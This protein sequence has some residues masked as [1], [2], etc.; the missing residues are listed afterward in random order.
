VS[1]ARLVDEEVAARLASDMT[2]LVAELYP[3]CRSI[4][5]DG[6]RTTLRRIERR[7]PLAVSEVPSGTPVY[8]WAVPREWNVRDASIS[9]L[10]G[11]R[12][13]DF[14]VSN[15]HLVS[16]SVPVRARMT[17]DELRPHLHTLPDQPHLVP[18]RTSY[19][20]EAWGF[21]L[22]QQQMEA[23]GEGPFDVEVDTTLEPGQLTYAECLLPGE[24]ADEVLVSTHVCHPS[25]ANDNL[26]GIAVATALAQLLAANPHRL[27]YRLVF[28]PG[29]IGSLT[30]LS[31]NE[32]VLDR[33]RHGLVITGLGGPGPLVWKR[34]RHGARPVDAAAEHVIRGRGGEVRDYSPW[35]YDERQYNSP[36]FDLPVGRLTRTPHGEYAEYHTSGDDL[37]F[38]SGETMAESLAGVL[39]VLD[40]LEN[41][42]V[43]LN[44]SPKGEPQLGR[45]GLYPSIGGRSAEEEVMSM[46]WLL[47]MADGRHTLL[48]V[49]RLAGLPFARVR[50]TAG[51]LRQHDLLGD[52]VR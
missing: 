13:V 24:T 49:A 18:Y 39:E 44:L 26:S 28:V 38:V 27:T 47:G 4:T 41:D 2:D 14:R 8:D 31:R 51:V 5:G 37:D 35:G 15:L 17:G 19:Y 33:I 29:T 25:L 3:V 1:V 9:D 42:V 10:S 7:V 16:Y 22:S 36:G 45:R 6:V 40:V 30:W 46:L 50:R 52:A 48:D 32:A 34:T 21:C 20:R 23:L 43:P 12:L 11:R